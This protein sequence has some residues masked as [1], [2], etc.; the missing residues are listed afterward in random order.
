[1]YCKRY[2]RE[3]SSTKFRGHL[4][5]DDF[6]NQ[7]YSEL[8]LLKKMMGNALLKVCIMDEIIWRFTK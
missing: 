1:M 7:E 6:N 8:S 2:P 5:C 3:K 4:S